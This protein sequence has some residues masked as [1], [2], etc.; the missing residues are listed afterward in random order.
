[1]CVSFHFYASHTFLE[2]CEMFMSLILEGVQTAGTAPVFEIFENQ[3][4]WTGQY[5]PL[6]L[7]FLSLTD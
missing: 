5:V 1:M 7:Y 3:I 4:L 2:I 6:H